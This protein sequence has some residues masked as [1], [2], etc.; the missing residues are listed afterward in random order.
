MDILPRVV[1]I[2][3]GKPLS[4]PVYRSILALDLERSTE[5]T[6]IEKAEQ[7]KVLYDALDDAL[8]ATGITGEQLDITDR[9]DGAMLLIRPDDNVPKPVL[10]TK[11]IPVLTELLAKYNCSITKPEAA[12]RLRAVIHAGEVLNDGR[13]FFGQALD[14]TFRLLDSPKLKNIL[15]E[16]TSSPL[17]LAVS[18]EIYFS[19]VCQDHVDR[20]AYKQLLR[21][22]V[23]KRLHLGWI[24]IPAVSGH[25][26][27]DHPALTRVAPQLGQRGYC[28]MA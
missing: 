28:R 9:G 1:R 8:E 18:E 5:R 6:D 2:P 4:G 3:N 19:I 10:L 20:G 12:L 24:H 13:G 7:R 16:T 23:S 25:E 17:V 21:V 11:L 27:E 15:R 22:R 26:P 14:I